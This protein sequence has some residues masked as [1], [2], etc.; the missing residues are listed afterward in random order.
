[1]SSWTGRNVVPVDTSQENQSIVT[2]T[3]TNRK[4][5]RTEETT[6]NEVY[7]LP[8]FDAI[9]ESFPLTNRTNSIITIIALYDD[10]IDD[11]V[12]VIQQGKG[13]AIYKKLKSIARQV[14][15]L[16]LSIYKKLTIKNMEEL[17]SVFI[18]VEGLFMPR[19][20]KKGMLETI[21]QHQTLTY[22]DVSNC[23]K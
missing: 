9:A 8:R 20:T 3:N 14:T 11:I 19:G 6:A 2:T 23:R 16:N 7:G 17:F 22:L 18:K 15:V 1:S 10:I 5:K 21:T 13:N 12:N 4:R